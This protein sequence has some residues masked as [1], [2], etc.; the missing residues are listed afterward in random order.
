[1]SGLSLIEMSS[2][3]REHRAASAAKSFGKKAAD[4]V[5]NLIDVGCRDTA[6]SM[7]YLNHSRR[8]ANK[9]MRNKG[10]GWEARQ[11]YI[12]CLFKFEVK[13]KNLL[14]HECKLEF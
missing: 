1:M 11:Y 4:S 9:N 13:S 7:L 5:S 14:I 2:D 3:W 6:A 10:E 8:F 12:K